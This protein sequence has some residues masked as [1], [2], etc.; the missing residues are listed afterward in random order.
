PLVA[1]AALGLTALGNGLVVF[2]DH[3]GQLYRLHHAVELGWLPWRLNPGWWAGDAEAQYYPPG[4]AWCGSPPSFTRLPWALSM[5]PGRTR[6]WPGS[7]GSFPA[8]PPLRSSRVC[9]AA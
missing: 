8:S 1:P 2:D 6:R 9:S 3:P 4:G 7:P 5:C